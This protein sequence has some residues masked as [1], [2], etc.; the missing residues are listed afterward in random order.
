MTLI[1]QIR[2]L[3]AEGNTER[4]L[5]ELYQY[6]KENNEEVIDTLVMLRGRMRAI[7]NE[8]AKGTMDSHTANLERSKIND[9]ILKLLPQLTP[10]YMANRPAQSQLQAHSV[11]QVEKSRP[12]SGNKKW[13]YIGSAALVALVILAIALIP[14]ADTGS[15][16]PENLHDDQGIIEND[17][18]TEENIITETSAPATEPPATALP[19]QKQDI[20]VV[21]LAG[22][23]WMKQN[24][25]VPVEGLSICYGDDDYN[26]TTKGRLYTWV[27]A[28][29]ACAALGDGWRLPTDADWKKLTRAFGG[30][31]GDLSYDGKQA[32][33]S[34]FVNDGKGFDVQFGGKRIFFPD[35]NS[36]GFYDYDAIAYYWADQE[37]KGHPEQALMYTFR[38]T[39]QM[40]LAESIRKEDYISCRC[41]K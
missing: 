5:D 16:T 1:D 7:Q 12:A 38:S 36:Y 13:A 28:R 11:T 17:G 26:C 3:I 34:L 40:V 8:V 21:Q 9:A 24:L 4:S 10:E 37:R 2:E 25:N 31:Y 6:V 18:S 41:V 33:I 22:L 27:G 14:R 39:D 35:H 19:V 32:Y 15:E 20:P 29:R 23:T 30:A